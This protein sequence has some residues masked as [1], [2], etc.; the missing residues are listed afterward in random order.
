[1]SVVDLRDP[2]SASGEE[3]DDRTRRMV[4][5][6]GAVNLAHKPSSRNAEQD[7]VLQNIL[8]ALGSSSPTDAERAGQSLA[9]MCA[10]D[11]SRAN[12]LAHP[13]CP[14]AIIRL[15]ANIEAP[16]RH[17]AAASLSAIFHLS[18]DPLG[19]RKVLDP[20]QFL[21]PRPPENIVQS[22]FSGMGSALRSPNVNMVIQAAGALNCLLL[23]EIAFVRLVNLPE[24][25]FR[26]LITG[27]AEVMDMHLPSPDAASHASEALVALVNKPDTR[28]RI[29]SPHNGI[30]ESLLTSMTSML[31]VRH[32]DNIREDGTPFKKISNAASVL[33]AI[34]SDTEGQVKIMTRH[35]HL[36]T[37]MD[38]LT[39][40]IATADTASIWLAASVLRNLVSCAELCE[41]LMLRPPEQVNAL[42]AGTFVLLHSTDAGVARATA[43]ALRNLALTVPGKLLALERTIVSNMMSGILML[44]AAADE[45]TVEAGCTTINSLLA[46]PL[47]FEVIYPQKGGGTN[48]IELLE[49]MVVALCQV[50]HTRFYQLHKPAMSAIARMVRGE[51][52][53]QL[54][55][56]W[57]VPMVAVKQAWYEW[58]TR[59]PEVVPDDQIPE[60]L[61]NIVAV[62]LQAM[63][64]ALNSEDPAVSANA[65]E[66]LCVW[67]SLPAIGW[68][69]LLNEEE[70]LVIRM[71]TGVTH[72]LHAQEPGAVRNAVIALHCFC[73]DDRG[74]AYLA[75]M[76]PSVI[77]LF[78]SGLRLHSQRSTD[79]TTSDVATQSIRALEDTGPACWR[80]WLTAIDLDA[81][82]VTYPNWENGAA[83]SCQNVGWSL[84]T[85]NIAN[86]MPPPP[87]QAAQE[88]MVPVPT[89][90]QT[91][92]VGQ[93][94]SGGLQAR[95]PNDYNSVFRS[96]KQQPYKQQPLSSVNMK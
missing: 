72:Q 5:G 54:L 16:D 66:I 22:M 3:V 30:L 17:A 52:G 59:E 37:L 46:E 67:A 41:W 44:L 8:H 85:D 84:H 4:F 25:Q 51:R 87:S 39:T 14:G 50:M 96:W 57:V 21:G 76:D 83:S 19:R 75:L 27:L 18:S 79:L 13:S 61:K 32:L 55:S 70:T 62:L 2:G 15:M 38:G 1:M 63:L 53:E 47:S 92:E 58:S 35:P 86:S 69:R 73:L 34:S 89:Y 6:I 65:T 90:T 23:S 95:V 74:Q 94:V 80:R 29:M 12:F 60:Y 20:Q 26:E 49:H 56:S 71:V 78:L 9:R 31:T 36:T 42:M 10:T 91:N 64:I 33:V 7:Q 45:V 82:I 11:D 48:E 81:P 93:Y 68:Q 40:V 24:S 28:L 88:A 77:R 43:L